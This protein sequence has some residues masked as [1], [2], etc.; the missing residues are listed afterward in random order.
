MMRFFKLGRKT[1]TATMASVMLIA[2]PF[3]AHK[4][5][6]RLKAYLDSGSIPTIC[7]GETENVKLGDVKTKEECDALFYTRL[8]AFAYGVDLLVVPDM[9]PQTHAALTSFAYNV[10]LEKFRNSTLL[11]KLNN[12]DFVG[13]CNELPRWNKAKGKVLAGLIKRR[14]DERKLCLSGGIEQNV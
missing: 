8:G 13:A 10:G 4:E 7:Y 6:L 9:Q 5:G 1:V 12:G 14:E 3:T 2:A 11:R